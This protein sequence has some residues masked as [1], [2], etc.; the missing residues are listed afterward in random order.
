MTLLTG[1][2]DPDAVEEEPY[3]F[4]TPPKGIEKTWDLDASAHPL[5]LKT[6][7][8]VAGVESLPPQS[9]DEF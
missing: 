9:T 4:P 8:R 7:T 3:E 1:F 2:P 6:R 5:I